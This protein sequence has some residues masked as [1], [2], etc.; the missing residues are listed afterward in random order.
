MKF[1]STKIVAK[2]CRDQADLRSKFDTLPIPDLHTYQILI[3]LI[4]LF[5]FL[6]ASTPAD[7]V[8]MCYLDLDW[9]AC[10]VT[11]GD[12]QMRHKDRQKSPVFCCKKSGNPRLVCH[13]T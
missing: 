1:L 4:T 6:L 5:V 8:S 10:M 13:A 3:Y 9:I 7:S 2:I 12:S 11:Y